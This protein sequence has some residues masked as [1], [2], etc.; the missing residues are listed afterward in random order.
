MKFKDLLAHD[1]W[2]GKDKVMHFVA[3]IGATIIVDPETALIGGF[4][5]EIVDIFGS[6]FSYKD[7]IW[8]YL[9]MAVG[10]LI[11]AFI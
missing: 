4:L 8:V 9:G 7:L 2:F 10:V 3:G 6:G 11:K 5:K 1:Y